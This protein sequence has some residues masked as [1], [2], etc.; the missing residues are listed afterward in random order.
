M[1]LELARNWSHLCNRQRPRGTTTLPSSGE[2]V[3]GFRAG[4]DVHCG[5]TDRIWPTTSPAHLYARRALRKPLASRCYAVW[6]SSAFAASTR[7]RPSASRRGMV[8][9]T[10]RRSSSAGSSSGGCGC[11]TVMAPKVTTPLLQQA[12]RTPPLTP[13]L[14]GAQVPALP[15]C[16]ACGPCRGPRDPVLPPP[17]A[18]GDLC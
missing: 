13:P 1:L 14:R 12:L 4:G 17:H 8:A 15:R 10:T 6:P 5:T 18:G 3:T 16:A 9:W 2:N 11:V 7:L